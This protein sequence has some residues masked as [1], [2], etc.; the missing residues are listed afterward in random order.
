MNSSKIHELI[1]SDTKSLWIDPRFVTVMES[2]HIL[3]DEAVK[4]KNEYENWK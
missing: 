1:D 4:I 2:M 3:K